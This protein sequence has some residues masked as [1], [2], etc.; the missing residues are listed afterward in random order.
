MRFLIAEVLSDSTGNE[1]KVAIPIGTLR[2]L[3][4]SFCFPKG[5]PEGVPPSL[6]YFMF[7]EKYKYQIT[8]K[9][10][11]QLS[12]VLLC[13]E[14]FDKEWVA[15]PTDEYSGTP[16]SALIIRYKHIDSLYLRGPY[17]ELETSFN[18]SHRLLERALEQ[19]I[20]NNG[21]MVDV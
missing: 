13:S 15:F 16:D 20:G 9:S 12:G 5:A 2:Y 7:T 19:A 8:V 6:E 3:Q 21:C 18:T 11:S 1:R 10:F 14:G 4:S 17:C